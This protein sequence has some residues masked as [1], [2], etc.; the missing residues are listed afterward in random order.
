MILSWPIVYMLTVHPSCARNRHPSLRYLCFLVILLLAWVSDPA[1]AS[2]KTESATDWKL[3]IARYADSVAGGATDV[4]LRGSRGSTTFWLGHYDTMGAGDGFRQ[5]RMGI[6]QTITTG[7]GRLVPSL[8]IAGGGFFN[9]SLTLE[10][11]SGNIKPILGV[12]RTNEKR[13]FNI[14]FDPNDSVQFG[15]AVELPDG[16]RLLGYAVRDDRISVGQQIVHFVYREPFQNG[17]RLVLD[18]FHRSGPTDDPRYRISA[19]GSSLTFDQAPYSIRLVYD[20]KVN[21]TFSNMWRLT[22]AYRF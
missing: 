1:S 13:F 11:G 14:N 21:F 7:L 2:E 15:A 9:Y 16:T 17:R 20:P 19:W 18:V 22:A 4:N 3:S 12:S 5:G 8:Q 10:A 6:E